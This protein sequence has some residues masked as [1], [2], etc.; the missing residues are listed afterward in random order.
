VRGE[1][2]NLAAIS[3]LASA[4]LTSRTMLRSVGVND[5]HPLVIQSAVSSTSTA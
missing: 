5:S 2:K 3:L 4:S 1:T